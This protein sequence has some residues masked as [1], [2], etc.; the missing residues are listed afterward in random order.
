MSSVG[1]SVV[2]VDDRTLTFSIRQDAPVPLDIEASCAPDE[3]LAIFGASGSGKTTLL[4]SIAGLYTPTRAN[5]RYGAECWTD[6]ERK[7]ALIPQERRVGMVFQEY[8]LFPHLSARGNV[9]AALGHQPAAKRAEEAD[10]WLAA[11]HL[12]GLE[13]RRPADLSGGQRQRVAIA[14]ALARRPRVLLLDEPFAAVDHATRRQLHRELDDLRQRIHIP[15]ILVT[16]DFH[17][18]ARL[19]T[20]VVLLDGGKAVAQGPITQ[21]TSRADV[22]WHPLVST[23]SV[24][25]GR[26]AA[27]DSKRGTADVAIEGGVMVVPSGDLTCGAVV[28]LRV[29][30]REVVLATAR[31]EHVS[32]HNILG[33]TVVGVMTA[34]DQIA[35]L[36]I[37]I[38]R[39]ALLAEV[40]RDAVE[41]LSLRPGNAVFALIKSVAVEVL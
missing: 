8:A 40:T 16:H 17:D 30:A 39:I 25:E 28:R 3:V 20:H 14:R 35:L 15:V 6:T 41:R 32:V 5:I 22:P 7:R 37:Q 13:E 34:S 27:I 31:P 29:P 18:V 9:M 4:R 33:G 26:V 2:F 1:D 21:L 23:G 12:A 36:Q 10:E 38:G 19:A 11:V 24:L